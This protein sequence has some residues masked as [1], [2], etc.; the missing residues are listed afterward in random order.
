MSSLMTPGGTNCDNEQ[1][2]FDPDFTYQAGRGYEQAGIGSQSMLLALKVGEPP[3]GWT[4][5]EPCR[6]F[7]KCEPL[8]GWGLSI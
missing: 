4:G 3:A 6:R 8:R 1:V 2:A 5:K 7:L